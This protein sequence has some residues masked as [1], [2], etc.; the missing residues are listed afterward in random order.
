VP[1]R[2]AGLGEEPS[3]CLTNVCL[4][5][6]LVK[7]GLRIGIAGANQDVGEGSSP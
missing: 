3:G 5:A 6:M 7:E 2:V 4:G 1:A